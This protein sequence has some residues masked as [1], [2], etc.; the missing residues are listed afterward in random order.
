MQCKKHVT[1]LSLGQASV[2]EPKL[3]ENG[4][5]RKGPL[6]A[7]GLVDCAVSNGFLG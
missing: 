1:N 2:V 5:F 7:L 6:L 3:Q 4:T